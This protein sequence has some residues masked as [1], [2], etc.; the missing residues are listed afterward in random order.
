MFKRKKVECDE[1]EIL[2]WHKW[3]ESWV[4]IEDW[5][6]FGPTENPSGAEPIAARCSDGRDLSLESVLPLRYRR[7]LLSYILIKIGI[8]ADPWKDKMNNS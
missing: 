3:G 1:V 4:S 5:M 6:K 8:L 7:N 2:I